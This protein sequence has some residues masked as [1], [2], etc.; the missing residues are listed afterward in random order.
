M[1][2]HQ[3]TGQALVWFGH[4]IT[5]EECEQFGFKSNAF[6]YGTALFKMPLTSIL[7]GISDRKFYYLGTRVY[8]R[9]YSQTILV[10]AA[11]SVGVVKEQTDVPH[12]LK[13]ESISING[14]WP[15]KVVVN[16]AGKY[17]HPEWAFSND[18][19]L[20]PEHV[21]IS[22]VDG[23]GET[24]QKEVNNTLRTYAT[25][26]KTIHGVKCSDCDDG[27][28]SSDNARAAFARQLK[29]KPEVYEKYMECFSQQDIGPLQLTAGFKMWCFDVYLA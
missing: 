18:I 22:F 2:S 26:V 6:R 4:E 25:C 9:E 12:F 15:F 1:S 11:T 20:K 27:N 19:D 5:L 13:E 10:S 7:S 21:Q 29:S 8:K 3:I 14:K 16:D 28:T 23:H 24:F 17:V